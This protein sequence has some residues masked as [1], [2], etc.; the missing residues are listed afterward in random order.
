M[1]LLENYCKPKFNS[2]ILSK[3]TIKSLKNYPELKYLFLFFLI[4][5]KQY[6]KN[7]LLF[8][9]V[10]NLIF[11][12]VSFTKKKSL[13]SLLVFKLLVKK[14]K[15]F[16]FLESFV[17]FYLPLMSTSENT[18]KATVSFQKRYLSKTCVFRYNYFMFPAISELDLMY[19]N[20]ELLYDFITNFKLQLDVVI[21]QPN[22]GCSYGDTLL[23]MYRLPFSSKLKSSYISK[24]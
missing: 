14:K 21:K 11:G 3:T 16:I 9:L 24:C 10:I 8:Y 23:R 18:F 20:Y 22:G 15:L 17:L 6:K 4:D 1:G 2:L 19:E 5:I 12:G 7:T 13:N